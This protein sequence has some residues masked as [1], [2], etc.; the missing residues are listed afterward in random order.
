MPALIRLRMLTNGPNGNYRV[1]AIVT[2]DAERAGVLIR[3]GHA[4]P[5]DEEVA[6]VATPE[7]AARRTRRPRGR[8]A[9]D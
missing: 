5:A 3:G 6:M 1:G 9:T 7:N 2:V 4:T 8:D